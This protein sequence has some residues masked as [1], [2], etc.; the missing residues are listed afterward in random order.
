MPG[1]GRYRRPFGATRRVW[2]LAGMTLALGLVPATVPPASGAVAAGVAS[3]SVA[4]AMAPLAGAVGAHTPPVAGPPAPVPEEVVSASRAPAPDQPH[5]TPE[6]ATYAV[7]TALNLPVK[8]ADGTLLRANVLFPA[9]PGTGVPAAGSF[10]VLLTQTPYGKALSGPEPALVQRGFIE[11]VADVRGTGDSH[12]QW[13]LFDPEQ[14]SDGVTLV[15]WAAGLPHSNGR[16]GLFGASYLGINQLLTAAAVGPGSPLKAIFP[17]VAASDVYRDMAVMGGIPDAEFSS[18]F[19]GLTAGLNTALPAKESIAPG[20]DQGTPVEITTVEK[21]H[22]SGLG[23]F[24]ASYLANLEQGGDLAYDGGYWAQRR[25]QS[26]LAAIVANRI[27]AYLVGG[28]HDIF[29]R[30]EP[31]NY[32]GLQNAWAGRPVDAPM[33]PDQPVTGRY[34]L[35]MGPWYHGNFG[36]GIDL[37]M[38][39]LQW[40][41]TWLRGEPTG[42]ERTPT[43]LHL[44]QMGGQRYVDASHWPLQRA[45]PQRLYLSAGRTGSAPWSLNDGGLAPEPPPLGSDPVAFA[46]G[47]TPC[48][49]S[50]DQWAGG[51]LTILLAAASQGEFCAGDDRTTQVGPSVLSYST[52]PLDHPLVIGGPIGVTVF[53]TSTTADAEWV[54]TVDDV[55]P[56]GVS[57]PLTQGALLGSLRAVDPGSSWADADG[58]LLLPH[59]PLTRQSA[60][61]L[62]AGK[63]TRFDIEVFP[64]F[65]SI[66]KGHSLRVAIS[67]SDTPHLVPT[68]EQLAHLVGGVYQVL[69]G[70]GAASYIELHVAD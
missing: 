24:H 57:T 4:A 45:H 63:I 56:D 26:V 12:G 15:Q 8:M 39:E 44:Y 20:A 37:A 59:H 52:A 13:G 22:L 25:P 48:S 38:L 60:S 7:F 35:L 58:G 68:P 53:A 32:V 23:T 1:R 46:G 3:G 34:Q 11:V 6:P 21:D 49:G 36:R 2:L 40:F 66:G 70:G 55:G 18:Y 43:P 17:E 69:R 27:P 5:W 9:D 54:V 29:Q 28:W 67:T 50:A 51:L 33:R 19:L 42:V 61:P 64:V 47:S 14:I 41:D 10:P 30:G 16:V 31:L 62:E 65:A